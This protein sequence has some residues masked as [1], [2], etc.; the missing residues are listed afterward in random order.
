VLNHLLRIM[1]SNIDVV[2]VTKQLVAKQI[3]LFYN[4]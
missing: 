1:I 4:K 3:Y 2:H